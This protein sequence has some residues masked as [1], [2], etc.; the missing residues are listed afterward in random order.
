MKKTSSIILILVLISIA[1]VASGCETPLA[2]I[3][4]NP[5]KYVGK[6]VTTSGIVNSTT[7]IMNFVMFKL[8]DAENKNSMLVYMQPGSML[9]PENSKVIV[10]GIVKQNFGFYIEAIEVK[11]LG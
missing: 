2:K 6:E 3:R 4:Q 10:R 1:L 5:E 11:V 7:K 9:P 8:Q